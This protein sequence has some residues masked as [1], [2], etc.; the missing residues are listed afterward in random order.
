[1]QQHEAGLLG[2]R[3]QPLPRP[4][5]P[6]I[7]LYTLHEKKAQAGLLTIHPSRW[8]YQGRRLGG[9]FDILSNEHQMVQVGEQRADHF[10]QLAAMRLQGQ[11]RQGR[12]HYLA[13][14][15]VAD[16]YF[17]YV[18]R[19]AAL[20][21]AVRDMMALEDRDSRIEVH[22]PVGLIDLL[23]ADSIFEVKNISKW[24]HGFG[25]LL[26]YGTYCPK[27]LKVL[28]LYGSDM[29]IKSHS[30]RLLVCEQMK[31]RLQYQAIL[32]GDHGPASRV[33]SLTKSP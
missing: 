33:G 28:R 3:Y 31:V 10:K 19:G 2:L 22:T 24:K 27:H 9:V 30:A 23:S 26:A 17:R 7:D 13:T 4:A 25:Q 5:M 6:S 21:C 18:P 32:S 12:G 20:E 1:M 11:L 14:P 16:R 29:D 8:L 15:A